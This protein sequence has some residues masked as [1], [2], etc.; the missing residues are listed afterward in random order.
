MGLVSLFGDIVYEGARSVNGPYLKVLGASAAVVGLIAGA[1][2][3]LGYVV[4][5]VSGYF[6]DRTKAYWLLTFLGYGMLISV[7]LMSLAGTWQIAAFF[8]VAERLGK[9]LRG[10]AR[11]TIVSQAAKQVGTGF[12]FGFSEAMDQIGAMAGPL[13]FSALFFFSKTAQGTLA[14]YQRGY[15]MLWIPF[16]L[17]MICVAAAFIRVPKP[18]K[19]EKAAAVEER[20]PD[21]SSKVFWLYNIFSFVATMGF[22]NFALVGYHLKAKGIMTDAQIPF[23]YMVAMAVDGVAALAIGKAYDLFNERLKTHT[24]GLATLITIPV[25]TMPVAMLVFSFNYAMVIAGVVL[26]GIVMGIH[27]TIMKSAIADIAPLRK[28]GT[29][30]GIFNT[31]YGLAIFAGSAAMGFLYDVSVPALVTLSVTL[32]TLSLIP[33]VAMMRKAGL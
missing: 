12:G 3:F 7:P 32:E 16:A 29:A 5:L 9:A 25:L 14:G 4:R 27:E 28:R 8:I 2:E 18:E 6:A 22:V 1:A 10:P 33:F 21:G 13:I 15:S 24:A 17:V 31:A 30:Y 23:F 20:E 11:D 26:W 19:L